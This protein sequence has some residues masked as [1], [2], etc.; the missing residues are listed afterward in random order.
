MLQD[1]FIQ[2]FSGATLMDSNDNWQD[3]A[4]SADIRVD[5]KPSRMS[6]SVIVTTLDPGAYTAIVRGVNE[7]AGIGI[8]EVFEID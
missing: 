4:A 1:P 6:E 2:L 7:T 3:H 5:L 8:V